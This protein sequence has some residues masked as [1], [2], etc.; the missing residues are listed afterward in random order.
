MVPSIEN[1]ELRLLIEN[2]CLFW[3]YLDGLVVSGD[4]KRM[5]TGQ[6]EQL[7][8][9]PSP[10]VPDVATSV[11][12]DHCPSTPPDYDYWVLIMEDGLFT[13]EAGSGD[14]DTNDLET[15]LLETSYPNPH[16]DEAQF[17]YNIN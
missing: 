17:Y 13:L 1:E 7:Q 9:E 8:K 14:K 3:E 10:L 15:Y 2:G 12:V 11:I 16:F 4:A 6:E 5:K